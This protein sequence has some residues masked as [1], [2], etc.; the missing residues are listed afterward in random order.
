M[1]LAVLCLIDFD[2]LDLESQYPIVSFIHLQHF[3]WRSPSPPLGESSGASFFDYSR[4]FLAFCLLSSFFFVF[5]KMA[6]SLAQRTLHI[7]VRR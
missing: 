4:K 1:F 5:S 3:N 7:V 2:L 6:S